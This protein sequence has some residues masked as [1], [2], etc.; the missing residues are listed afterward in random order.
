MPSIERLR[1]VEWLKAGALVWI[2]LGHAAERLCGSPYFGNPAHDWPPLAER[3][4]QLRPISGHGMVG[5]LAANALR[6]VGW[7]GDQ[8][9]SVFLILSGFGLAWGCLARWGAAP[10][11]RGDFFRR[12]A[13][14]L[15]PLWWVAHLCLL[16][17]L[18]VLG[19]RL[20]LLDS[21]LYFS[22]AG[23]R[24]LPDQLYYGVAAWWFVP[25]LLQFYLVFPL[26]WIVYRRG[27]IAWLLAV[28]V[29]LALPLRAAG[30]WYFDGYLDAWSRGAVFV[31]RL[32]EFGCGM[33]LACWMAA[34]PQPRGAVLARP[35]VGLAGLV[36][37]A[38]GAGLSLTLT[39]M[40]AAPL[41]QGLGAFAVLYVLFSGVGRSGQSCLAPLD[42][43][44]HHSYSLY[45]VHQPLVSALLPKQGTPASG[46]RVGA[47]LVLAAVATA[48]AALLLEKTAAVAGGL[49]QRQYHR[50]GAWRLAR[51]AALAA[52]AAW[53]AL[54]AG[55]LLV[56]R[57]DPQEPPDL[58]WGE[59]PA[60]EPHADF[61]W[62]LKPSRS[63]R[64]R[65]L[66]YDY[67]VEANSLGFPGPEYPAEKGAGVFRVLVTGDAFT[68]A[69]GVDTALA[70]PR[71]LEER[72]AA[73][74]RDLHVQVLN[75]AISG[76]GP[77]QYAA[78][79]EH[80]A[81]RYRPD[82][83]LIGLF[84][85]DYGDVMNSNEVMR[86]AIGF[87][88]PDPDGLAAVLTCRHLASLGRLTLSR[89]VRE[90]LLR[91]PDVQG[92]FLGQFQWLQRDC[93]EIRGEGRT[94]LARRVREIKALADRLGA[95][96][97]LVMV[98][99]AGQV[100]GAE[101]LAYWPRHVD[102]SDTNCFDVDLPQRTTQEIAAA[103]SIPCYDLRAALRAVTPAC[104]CQPHN[105]HWTAPGHRA[106]ADYLT[107]E[108]SKSL[109]F[110]NRN[111]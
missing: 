50:L 28:T 6:Y 14:R 12:R 31:S 67:R 48:A 82:L 7:L 40:A 62:R 2:F 111:Q 81:P 83:I 103:L 3:L 97:A 29:G 47:G 46:W 37:F 4:A 54:V 95:R 91:R 109:P 92:Y 76:Y 53:M 75:F 20:S 43:I 84:A 79:L 74:H 10:P 80:F 30:L 21:A 87:Q 39:G 104:P 98:P 36:L 66:S 44:G 15:L 25:L 106:V 18:A 69:E 96:L 110:R 49:V 102:L 68:S 23:I 94:R 71:L 19:W 55:E 78:V 13:M 11:H 8:G 5:D 61:G 34:A 58:G 105:M 32:P 108:L 88:R 70:W 52:G 60:L 64:L 9:V 90:R 59:R 63:T 38:V 17:P 22:F 100:S 93:A 35:L 89:F 99:T 57:V 1:W 77:D 56:R 42:W 72:L 41:V 26:L 27:G 45:L 65:W 86:Q 85:N 107:K 16:F 33:A 101:S 24:V 73:E 51:R